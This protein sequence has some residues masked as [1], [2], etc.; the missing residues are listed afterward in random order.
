MI[1][2]VIKNS[3]INT[4]VHA[5]MRGTLNNADYDRLVNMRSVPEAAEYLKNNTRFAEIFRG[6]D[7]ENIHRGQLEARLHMLMTRD[8]KSFLA[9][10]GTSAKFFLSLFAIKDEIVYLKI[11]LR[12]I[13]SDSPPGFAGTYRFEGDFYNDIDFT[14][15]ANAKDFD[16][17]ANMLSG[18]IYGKVFH[19]FIGHP[20]RQN[21]FEIENALDLFYR[22][23]V[24]NYMSKYLSKNEK[25]FAE[26]TFGAETD[27]DNI[28]LIVRA[29]KY[30]GMTADMIY[31]YICTKSYRLK[32]EELQSIAEADSDSGMMDAI[33]KTCY[34]RL[35]SGGLKNAESRISVYTL[36]L[37]SRMF[38]KNP[39][40]IESILYFIKLKQIEIKNIIMIIEGIRYG[41]EPETIKGYLI[42]V[43]R[44]QKWE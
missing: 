18:T 21:L 6:I 38:H 20:K 42:G 31:P 24:F 32:K 33:G 19:S 28:M 11:L 37:H 2:N 17:F 44:S 40:S 9:F 30:Y 8:L 35:F 23:L 10:S 16:T 25:G 26:K 34:A 43:T 14:A 15:L 4:K 13:M 27:I 5:K 12:L 3:S 1:T 36:E 29:K 39:Y 7:V 22:N 41:V